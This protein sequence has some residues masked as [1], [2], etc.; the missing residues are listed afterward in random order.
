MLG[1]F[2]ASDL[3]DDYG[4]ADEVGAARCALEGLL[5][6]L[7]D[8]PE[9]VVVMVKEEARRVT[10]V[11]HVHEKDVGLV[12]GVQGRMADAVRVLLLKAQRKDRKGRM[13]EY[14][15]AQPVNRR[16]DRG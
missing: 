2:H 15:V 3:P 6:V 5:R 4:N 8:F 16:A 10:F 14:E 11:A 13:W 12:I 1:V 7:A 9:A